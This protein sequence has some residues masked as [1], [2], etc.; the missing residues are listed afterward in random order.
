MKLKFFPLVAFLAAIPLM[1]L[2]CS[3]IGGNDEHYKNS[4]SSVLDGTWNASGPIR[5]ITLS[6]NNWVYAENGSDYSRGT[7]S[8]NFTVAYGSSGKLTLTINEINYGGSWTTFPPEYQ[9]YKTNTVDVSIDAVG[10]TMIL[11]NAV[12]TTPG[13][14]GTTEGIYIKNSGGGNPSGAWCVDHS[15]GECT[16]NPEV[17]AS[18]EACASWL[19]VFANSCPADYER[20]DYYGNSSSSGGDPSGAWCVDHYYGECTNDP[21]YTSSQENCAYWEGILQDYCPVDY[22]IEDYYG[23]GTWCVDHDWPACTDS[24]YYTSSQAACAEWDGVLLDYC[25]A[26]YERY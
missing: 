23:G 2:A 1:F 18:Q 21:Y 22:Y 7:W 24:P 17:L 25:P 15:N 9:T 26:N 20:Y 3:D 10:N 4:S 12:L 8:A 16:N 19:G 5:S 14:W 6:G 13:I 11:S